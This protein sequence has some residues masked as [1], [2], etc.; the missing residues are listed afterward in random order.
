MVDRNWEQYVVLEII[1][2]G[3]Y[4]IC[5]FFKVEDDGIVINLLGYII[6]FDVGGKIMGFNQFSIL[7]DLI[8]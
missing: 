2:M 5:Y 6:F 1:D 3:G 8:M 4:F 7:D